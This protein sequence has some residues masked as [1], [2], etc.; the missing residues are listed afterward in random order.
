MIV[1]DV[2]FADLGTG[3]RISDFALLNRRA[4]APH[5]ADNRLV[6]KNS[7]HCA[8]T[9]IAGDLLCCENLISARL[10]RQT[11]FIRSRQRR[12][13]WYAE[14]VQTCLR[15]ARYHVAC[16]DNSTSLGGN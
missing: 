1:I 11:L 3:G 16:G 15:H 13:W 9:V 2:S 7:W 8:G 4:P 14:A 5:S 12:S 10:V 6:S